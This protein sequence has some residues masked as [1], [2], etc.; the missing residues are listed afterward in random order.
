MIS[1]NFGDAQCRWSQITER[2]SQF[3]VQ[4]RDDFD[5]TISRGTSTAETGPRFDHTSGSGNYC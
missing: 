4:I 5:W 1:C 3:G 2:W